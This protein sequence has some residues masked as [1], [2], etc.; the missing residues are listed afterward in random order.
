MDTRARRDADVTR[1]GDDDAG[2]AGIVGHAPTSGRYPHPLAGES[3][4]HD[5]DPTA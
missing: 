3:G 2:V 1:A 4:A 5:R